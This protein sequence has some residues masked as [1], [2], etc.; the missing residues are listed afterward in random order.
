MA[1]SEDE[2]V[3]YQAIRA[4]VE[5]EDNLLVARVGWLIGSE[6][7]LFAAYASALKGASGSEARHL[8]QLLPLLG[9]GIAALIAVAIVAALVAIGRLKRLALGDGKRGIPALSS[10]LG[11][12]PVI[13]SPMLHGF[14][15]VPAIG[16]PG[17]LIV[18]WL[19][20]AYWPW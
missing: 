15:L 9:I 20:T 13:G 11:M 6:A 19:Y 14:G 17:V 3:R 8:K 18:V 12:P 16:L 2:R 10:P 7:F 1:F 5:H 4:Q